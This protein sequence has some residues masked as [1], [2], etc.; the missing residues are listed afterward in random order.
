[1]AT[2]D[3]ANGT[4]EDRTEGTINGN[5]IGVRREDDRTGNKNKESDCKCWWA[6]D[7]KTTERATTL[8]IDGKTTLNGTANAHGSH[9]H[10]HTHTQIHGELVRACAVT[11]SRTRTHK[12]YSR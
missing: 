9:T 5:T 7:A 6:A 12:L 2:D 1:M 10:A 4:A 8:G 11:R 3:E